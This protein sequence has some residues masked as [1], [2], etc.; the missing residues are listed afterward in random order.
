MVRNL[1]GQPLAKILILHREWPY[2]GALRG[3]ALQF[4][5]IWFNPFDNI[6]T[7]P[8]SQPNTL[9]LAEVLLEF[10]V[11]TSERWRSCEMVIDT[12]TRRVNANQ[13]QHALALALAASINRLAQSSSP[14][15]H[16]FIPTA[17][18]VQSLLQL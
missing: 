18:V 5:E 6:N 1:N 16:S 13:Q 7:S 17:F 15:I 3:R 10:I 8:G 2:A 4:E 14:F 12:D 9:V 11:P